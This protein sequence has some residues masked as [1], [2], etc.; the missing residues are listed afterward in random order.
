MG[1]C[2]FVYVAQVSSLTLVLP[3]HMLYCSLLVLHA[4]PALHYLVL[5][6]SKPGCRGGFHRSGYTNPNKESSTDD[7]LDQL[8]VKSGNCWVRSSGFGVRCPFFALHPGRLL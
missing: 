6:M 8:L 7:A 4:A 1:P 2:A 3:V 5:L